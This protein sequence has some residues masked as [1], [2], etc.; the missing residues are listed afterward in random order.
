MNEAL[1][2]RTGTWKDYFFFGERKNKR[3]QENSGTNNK[4]YS[5]VICIPIIEPQSLEVQREL[6][7][8][9]ATLTS[10]GKGTLSG[11]SNPF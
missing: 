10:L 11:Y 9:S 1:R 2:D 5:H 7:Y 3:P 8:R 4:V 6:S